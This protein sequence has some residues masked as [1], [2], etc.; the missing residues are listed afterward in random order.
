MKK[1]T[2]LRLGRRSWPGVGGFIKRM[3]ARKV[4][5]SESPTRERRRGKFAGNTSNKKVR[6][7]WKRG[8]LR[9]DD[10]G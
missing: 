6:K 5:R 2:G 1:K 8:K 4:E 10:G 7:G 3:Q 9:S